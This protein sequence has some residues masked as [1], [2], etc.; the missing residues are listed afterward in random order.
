V[1][2]SYEITNAG[3]RD[4]PIPGSNF[5][6]VIS[7]KY[8]WEAVSDS[9]K[10]T[11]LSPGTLNWE[12]SCTRHRT[13]HLCSKKRSRA[14]ESVAIHNEVRPS[15]LLAPGEF[16]L[17]VTLFSVYATDPGKPEEEELVQAFSVEP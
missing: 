1:S 3:K 13:V 15:E 14:G 9:A 17:H 2:V 6:N 4:I 7:V 8:G 12:C 10:K 5:G 11:N 16:R